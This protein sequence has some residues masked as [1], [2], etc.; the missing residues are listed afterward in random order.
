MS[1][2]FIDGGHAQ[3]TRAGQIKDREM[4]LTEGDGLTGCSLQPVQRWR[5]YSLF[6]SFVWNFTGYLLSILS[7]KLYNLLRRWSNGYECT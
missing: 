7:W 6:C 4:V 5:D 2:V 1:T 3:C